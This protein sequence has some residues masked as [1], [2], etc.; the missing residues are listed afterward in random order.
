MRKKI[1]AGN[2]KMNGNVSFLE[3]I[4]QEISSTNNSSG[5]N[6]EVYIFPPAHLLWAAKKK[7]TEI[8]LGAQNGYYKDKG[9]FTG[10]ISMQ[11]I[12]ELGCDAVLIGHSERRAIF[13]E[14]KAL[15]KNKVDAALSHGLKVFFCCG[16]Q[17]EDRESGQQESIVLQQLQAGIFHLSADDIKKIVIAYEPVWAIGTGKTASK[18][19]AQ[20]MHAAIRKAIS[21]KYDAETAQSVTILYGGSCNAQNA[22]QLFAQPDIDGGLIGGAALVAEDFKK[23]IAAI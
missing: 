13:K 11:Q 21:E 18:E 1:V 5:N 15:L 8:K 23:I 7:I 17:L 6:K 12:K 14:D 10:E 2:W 22:Q 16:E 9:A 20:E 3:N 19:D 4:L